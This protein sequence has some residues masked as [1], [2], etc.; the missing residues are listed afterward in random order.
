VEHHMKGLSSSI[1]V[2]VLLGIVHAAQAG[3]VIVR[4]NSW[5]TPPTMSQED[6]IRFDDEIDRVGHKTNADC[7][8]AVLR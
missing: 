7:F 2:C 3:D 6:E 8:H 1:V 5:Y 4:V